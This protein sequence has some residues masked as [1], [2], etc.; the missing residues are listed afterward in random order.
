MH[1]NSDP[2]FNTYR[3]VIVSLL[4]CATTI[5]YFDRIILSLL[6]PEIKKDLAINDIQYSYILSVFQLSYTIGALVAGKL[7]DWAGTKIGYLITIFFWS[8]A[9]CMHATVGSAF[10]LGIWR[11]LLGISESGNFPAAIKSIS[12]W[13]HKKERSFATSLFNSGPNIAM[14]TGAPIIVYIT[15]SLGWRVA[16]LIM[17]I[18]GFVL[19]AVWPF[20]YKKPPEDFEKVLNDALPEGGF[21]WRKLLMYRETYGIMIGKFLTDPVWWFYIFWLPNYLNAQ[22]GFD[23]K[24]TALAIPFIY[25]IAIVL[26]NIGGWVPGYLMKR[27]WSV[28]NARKTTMLICAL[29]L[30]VTAFAVQVN[31]VW[32][33]I[34]LISLA[35]GAHCGWSA[36]IFTLITDY[37]PSKAAGSV[38]GL[39]SFSGGVGGFL[40]STFAVGYIV[41]YIGYVPIFIMMGVLHPIAIFFIYLFVRKDAIAVS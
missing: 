6:I 8:F 12:E 16:F 10:S 39:A 13:F 35:C 37:F 27:G 20:L 36:N 3:W 1:K 9:A 31:N 2:A 25:I 30:P 14:I 28:N 17:G 19:A 34:L 40:I 41:T 7:I 21:R 33:A 15:L 38:T 26:G 4:F 29:C 23:L 24:K 5:N 11:G 22:R 32:L 18:T